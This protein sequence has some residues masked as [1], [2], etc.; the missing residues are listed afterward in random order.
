MS[1]FIGVILRSFEYG[2][3]YALASLSIILVY[4]TSF[5]TNFAQGVLGMFNTY[6]I[7]TLVVSKGFS[8][9]AAIP[10]GILSAVIIG[11][12]IDVIIIR[13]AKN[14]SPVG[15][16]II[17]LGILNIILGVTPLTFGVY[18]LQLPKIIPD[19]RLDILGASITYNSLFNILFGLAVMLILFN[20]LSKTKF[21]LAI[22][23]TAS[24]ETTARMMGV[25]TKTITMVAWAIAGVLSMFA[26]VMAAPFSAVNTI[27]MNDIQINAFMASVFGG[28][29]TFHGP[30]V[31]AYILSI[32]TNLLQVYLPNGTV[33]GKPIVYALMIVFL[34]FRPVGLFGKKVV[35][36]V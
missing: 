16:Q 7:A 30:V 11:I 15:K 36:K 23:T 10:F 32:A 14:V 12:L 8:I 35:K 26:G 21:G 28:F 20:I 3:I 27:F 2:S 18:D 13:R 5:T 19:G 31:G 25:S 22:R 1:N 9:Y 29:S 34:Y 33:W 4:K 6:L 24:N 17:T